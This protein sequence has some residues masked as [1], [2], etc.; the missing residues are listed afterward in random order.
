MMSDTPELH[1]YLDYRAFLADWFAA[2]K[3][4]NPRYSHRAFVRRT[5]QKS[6]SLLADV[7]AGRRNLTHSSAEGFVRALGLSTTEARFFRLLVDLEQAS[8]PAEKNAAWSG[9]AASKRF[10]EA[11]RV[12]GDSMRYLSTW[13]VPVIRELARRPDFQADPAWIARQLRPP[14]RPSE[15]EEAL[16]LLLDLDLLK[17]TDEGIAQSGGTVATAREVAGL[18]AHNYHQGMLERA[19]SAL[20]EVASTERHF[21]AVTVT[22]PQSLLPTLKEELNALQDR[23]LDLCGGTDAGI[24]PVMQFHLHFFPLSHG[25]E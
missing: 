11:R 18:A 16:E 14:I 24:D 9:I 25:D 22:A 23:I 8:T 19:Q 12:A 5:G 6:P 1:R 20:H 3:A 15:A 21:L 7:I 17:R 13:Y 2:K 4:S 10:R